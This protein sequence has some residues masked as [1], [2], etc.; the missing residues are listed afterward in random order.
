MCAEKKKPS[1]DVKK[2]H[3]TETDSKI[4]KKLGQLRRRRPGWFLAGFLALLLLFMFVAQA[5]A[6]FSFIQWFSFV[7]DSSS[8]TQR[9]LET[10][11]D[12]N[13]EL[14]EEILTLKKQI[15][16][17]EQKTPGSISD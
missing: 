8:E 2:K 4:Q 10:V 16:K 14:S 7:Q 3:R 15:K 13:E 5:M 6:M 1:K 12:H 9:E 11:L 17:L